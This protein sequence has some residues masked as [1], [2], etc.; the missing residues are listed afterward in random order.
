MSLFTVE[1]QLPALPGMCL[2]LAKPL[3]CCRE[4]SAMV[5]VWACGR[6]LIVES[7]CLLW[8]PLSCAMAYAVRAWRF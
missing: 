5:L 2:P 3:H 7:G 4:V 8:F 1:S 6:S